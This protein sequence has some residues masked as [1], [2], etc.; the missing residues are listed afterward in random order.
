MIQIDSIYE[1]IEQILSFI[2]HLKLSF[3]YWIPSPTLN[4][5]LVFDWEIMW[6]SRMF[7]DPWEKP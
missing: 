7:I 5:L 4:L 3:M 2:Y 1:E 6:N